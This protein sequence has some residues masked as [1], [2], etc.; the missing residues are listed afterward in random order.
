MRSIELNVSR[1]DNAEKTKTLRRSGA[2]PGVCYGAGSGTVS[3]KV[4][5]HE[6]SR[7]GLSGRGAHLIRFRSSEG[8]LDQ[9]LALI[10]EIQ[11]HPVTGKPLH[12]DFLRIDENKPVTTRV[13][14]AFVGKAKGIIDGGILQPIVREIDVRA[15]PANLPEQVD[16]DVTP[17]GVHDS[18]HVADLVM[19]A[20]VEAVFTENFTIV[21]VA[22][23]TVEAAP[24]PAEGT[25]AAAAPAAE[26]AAAAS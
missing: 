20:G 21:T 3:V 25:E 11:T 4:D 12:V 14:L 24:T 16:V 19:P 17:L 22:A 7:S 26:A 9:R 2:L 6:F 18:L 1:R 23:P 8:A 13:A 10:H 5:A 15:L